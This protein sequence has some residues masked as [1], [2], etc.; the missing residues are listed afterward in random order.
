MEKLKVIFKKDKENNV[1]G[2][3]P[4]LPANLGKIVCYEHIGQHREADIRY[5]H[6]LK[7][8]SET[9]YAALLSELRSIYAEDNGECDPPIELVVRQRFSYADRE[10]AYDWI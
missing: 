10:K 9:E 2:F 7:K 4:E 1:I 3:F 5:F 8:A 6:S